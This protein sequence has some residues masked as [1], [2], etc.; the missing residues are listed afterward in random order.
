MFDLHT[1]LHGL[2]LILHLWQKVGNSSLYGIVP[3]LSHGWV[4]C[5]QEHR[6][7]SVGRN[8]LK[9]PDVNRGEGRKHVGGQKWRWKKLEKDNT[10]GREKKRK[11]ETLKDEEEVRDIT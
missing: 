5:S 9:I 8:H 7:L 11:R 6:V 3:G 2:H 10:N 4:F 1:S